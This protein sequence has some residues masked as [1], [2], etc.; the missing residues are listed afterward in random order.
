MSSIR[1]K[2]KTGENT[3]RGRPKEKITRNA[4]IIEGNVKDKRQKRRSVQGYMGRYEWKM[5]A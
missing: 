5:N 3:Y 4:K 1:N 2:E